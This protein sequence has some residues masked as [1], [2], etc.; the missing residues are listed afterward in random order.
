MEEAKPN[1]VNKDS[2]MFQIFIVVALDDFSFYL[3]KHMLQGD[4]FNW[5]PP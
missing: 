3:G 4:F 5:S 1:P 2:E